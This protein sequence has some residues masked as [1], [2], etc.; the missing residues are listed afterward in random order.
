MAG[1]GFVDMHGKLLIVCC[2]R[3]TSHLLVSVRFRRA[4][5][6]GTSPDDAERS[7]GIHHMLLTNRFSSDAAGQILHHI[8]RVGRGIIWPFCV[9]LVACA[10]QPMTAPEV[11][12]HPIP[13]VSARFETPPAALLEALQ[14][15]C[16]E[17]TQ[18]ITQ[19]A[20]G[21][22][23]CRTLLDP[24]TTAGAILR[25]GGTINRL[26]ESVIRL[27]LTPDSDGFMVA[28]AAYLEVPRASG[29]VL[30]VVFPDPG[31]DRRIRRFLTN[32]GGTPP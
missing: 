27:R 20:A 16:N 14:Q 31:I 3:A 30:R 7:R 23:E 19:P 25:Y 2:L 18:R 21:V 13:E 26:P 17:P 10:P 22:T 15:L 28:S 24:Q 4:A 1:D 11:S 6:G 9:I 8:A 32:L 12:D 29:D 5:Y